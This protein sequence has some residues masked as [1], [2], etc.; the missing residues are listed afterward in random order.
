MHV[1]II[2][3]ALLVL[4]IVCS[5]FIGAHVEKA[6][7]A[8]HPSTTYSCRMCGRS[9]ATTD[10]LDGKCDGCWDRDFEATSERLRDES[11]H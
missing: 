8:R 10:N 3:I 5:Y 4:F 1:V 11:D 2:S 9:V 7:R 6:E